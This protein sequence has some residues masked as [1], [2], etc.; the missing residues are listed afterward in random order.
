MSTNS[1]LRR[2]LLI[3]STAL[4]AT[5]LLSAG[6]SPAAAQELL[7]LKLAVTD[8][9]LNPV[10]DSALKLALSEGF[11]ERHGLK[12]ELVLLEGTPQAVAALNSGAVDLADI[13]IDALLRLRA[14]NDIAIKGITSA[15]LGP[16]YLIAAKTDIAS[17][18]DLAGHTYAIA[19]NGSLDH[20]L[21]QHV[22]EALGLDRDG[23]EFVAIGAPGVRVRALAAGQVDATTVSYGT[24]LPIANTEG[25]HIIVQPEDFFAAAPIQSK[26]VVTLES[27]IAE[28]RE[29]LQRFVTAQ[30]DIARTYDTD[31]TP[32][33]DAVARL[34]TDLTRENL[35]AT[36]R[37]LHGRWCVN[38]CV[39]LEDI[40]A[41]IDFIYASDDF[42]GVPVVTAAD[43]TDDSFALQSIQELGPYDGGGIDARF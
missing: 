24:Y 6:P 35:E 10:T 20:T 28:K 34:R 8:P 37:F 5:A 38:G 3:G 12:I 11:Y 36:T 22:L 14:E 1:T 13:S 42:A 21:T 17:P 27:T 39:N 2:G 26:L 7:E 16:P 41:T 4:V 19:D 33:V 23:P 40:Q 43:V 15:T 32:W 25:L 29:A 30:L 18:A 9:A 31:A